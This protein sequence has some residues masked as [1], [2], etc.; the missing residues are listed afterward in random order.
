MDEVSVYLYEQHL[1]ALEVKCLN[2]V[3]IEPNAPAIQNPVMISGTTYFGG[4]QA[5]P[6]ATS[7]IAE[8][9]YSTLYGSVN[10]IILPFNYTFTHGVLTA[11]VTIGLNSANALMVAALYPPIFNGEL[12]QWLSSLPVALWSNGGDINTGPPTPLYYTVIGY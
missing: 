3:Y 2:P 5:S 10:G 1:K 4:T 9:T 6:A 8:Q 12:N 11:V 7:S